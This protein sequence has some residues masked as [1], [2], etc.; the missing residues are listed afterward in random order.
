MTTIASDE[1]SRTIASDRVEGTTVYNREGEKL[2]TISRFMVDKRT[3]QVDY[4]VLSFGGL[5][6]LGRDHYPLPWDMLDYDTAQGGYVVDL[7][8]AVLEGAPRYG[9]DQEPVYDEDYGR[10]V[11]GYYNVPYPY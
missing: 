8:K 4:A 7:D 5:F 3:G 10:Q 2:G 11:Y 6:G 9:E 1:T